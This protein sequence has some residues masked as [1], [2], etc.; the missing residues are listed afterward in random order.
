MIQSLDL[1]NKA[2]NVLSGRDRMIFEMRSGLNDD[3][4]AHNLRDIGESLDLTHERVRQI[5]NA[6]KP[7]YI[8]ELER[9][10][11]GLDNLPIKLSL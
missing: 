3:M 6:V 10:T 9:L 1:M 8:K 2:L 7:K 4:E 11:G 5:Y